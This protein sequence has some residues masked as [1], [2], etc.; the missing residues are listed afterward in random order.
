MKLRCFTSRKYVK[1]LQVP[2]KKKTK[3]VIEK[4]CLQ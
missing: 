1:R 3:K 2:E 4:L